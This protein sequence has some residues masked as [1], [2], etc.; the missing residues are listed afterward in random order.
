MPGR[1]A[2]DK[3]CNSRHNTAAR[4]PVF[5]LGRGPEP[6]FSRITGDLAGAGRPM[7]RYL[8]EHLR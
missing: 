7:G 1:H 6:I 3:N 8:E 5:S 4:A 2:A